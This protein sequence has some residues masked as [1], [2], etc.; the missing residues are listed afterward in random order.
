MERSELLVRSY[1]SAR[2]PTAEAI[3][4]LPAAGRAAARLSGL[5]ASGSLSSAHPEPEA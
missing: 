5:G 3:N 2:V 1:R 4:N